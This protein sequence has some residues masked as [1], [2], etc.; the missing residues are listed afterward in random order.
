M[1]KNCKLIQE[2][3]RS[4][5]YGALMGIVKNN[6]LWRHSNI[7]RRYSRFVDEDSK[8]AVMTMIEE[9][10]RTVDEIDE[11]VTQENAEENTMDILKKS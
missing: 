2:T 8:E 9:L 4:M 11:M 7:D 1:A 3:H 10:L 5:V 6:K